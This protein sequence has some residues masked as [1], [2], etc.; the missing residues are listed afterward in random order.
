MSDND[1][2]KVN[3]V[4]QVKKRVPLHAQKPLMVA[5]REGYRRYIMND[6]PGAR[7]RLELAGYTAVKNKA[8]NLCDKDASKGSHLGSDLKITVNKGLNAPSVTA[9]VMEIPIEWYEEDAAA[10][11][12]KINKDEEVL[13]PAKHSVHG[14][15]YGSLQKE[16]DVKGRFS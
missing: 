13:D 7:E 3:G 4:Q 9:T 8:D 12:A 10:A 5:P 11:Q 16:T 2:Y 1:K 15:K 14:S 6:V